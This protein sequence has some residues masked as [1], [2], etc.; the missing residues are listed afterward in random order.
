MKFEL[1]IKEGAQADI[2]ESF[3][4]YS[5]INPHLGDDFLHRLDEVFER[6]LSG[7][8]MF[9][10]VFNEIRQTRTERFPYV[11]SYLIEGDRIIVLTVLHGHR[12]P[13]VW[14]DRT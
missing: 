4:R 6:I 3:Q 14:K 7:P 9:A 10:K 11:V 1:L 2:T 8:E 5:K 13:N 12:N